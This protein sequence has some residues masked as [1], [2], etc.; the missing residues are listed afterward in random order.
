MASPGATRRRHQSRRSK[1]NHHSEGPT[2]HDQ[3][4]SHFGAVKSWPTLLTASDGSKKDWVQGWLDDVQAR[5]SSRVDINSMYSEKIGLGHGSKAQPAQISPEASAREDLDCQ[6][7]VKKAES[8]LSLRPSVCKDKHQ[9]LLPDELRPIIPC[10]DDRDELEPRIDF[11]IPLPRMHRMKEKSYN[12]PEG[13]RQYS[14]HETL[15]RCSASG[16]STS[17]E[18][19]PRRKTRDDR[20]DT[21]K[22]GIDV[23][24]KRRP[25]KESRLE[26]SKRSLRNT[27]L[28]NMTNVREVMTKFV[29]SSVFSDRITV[30]EVPD[31]FFPQDIITDGKKV[32]S[33]TGPG[34]FDNGRASK[35]QRQ[36]P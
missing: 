7:D 4:T 13:K 20:Y 15:S 34:L 5:K 31:V 8:V 19:K 33:N 2:S 25:Q 10:D 11:S 27:E 29:P 6:L 1:P 16:I 30:S 26:G 18:R 23:G 24:I 35:R 14:P 12:K 17:F 9:Q 36:S 28:E 21:V 22:R 3:G 32:P